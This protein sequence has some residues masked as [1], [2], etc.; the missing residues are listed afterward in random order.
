[1]ALLA[2]I[3]VPAQGGEGTQG[4]TP[5]LRDVPGRAER[6]SQVVR[7]IRVKFGLFPSGRAESCSEK[8]QVG[9]ISASPSQAL[10]GH[11][12]NVMRKCVSCFDLI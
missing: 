6:A 2:Q 5:C 8:S 1:M 3:L 4:L 12:Q 9:F 10:D 7:G 11:S